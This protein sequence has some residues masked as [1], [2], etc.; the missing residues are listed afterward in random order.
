MSAQTVASGY[1]PLGNLTEITD[2]ER[3]Q[4]AIW[5]AQGARTAD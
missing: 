3:E 1:M 5:F 2:A 4:I